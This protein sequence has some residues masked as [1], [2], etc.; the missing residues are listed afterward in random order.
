MDERS[1]ASTV[2]IHKNEYV[3]RPTARNFETSQSKGDDHK[4]EY[5]HQPMARK[6]YQSKVGFHKKEYI[7]QPMVPKTYRRKVELSTAVACARQNHYKKLILHYWLERCSIINE[8]STLTKRVQ[9][10]ERELRL[11]VTLQ[12][13]WPCKASRLAGSLIGQRQKRL[14]RK[15]HKLYEKKRELA[16]TEARL[17]HFIIKHSPDLR[18]SGIYTSRELH[19]LSPI[20]EEIHTDVGERIW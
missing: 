3:H 16:T 13:L 10:Y 14:T 20:P 19:Y 2:D 4:K 1:V 18:Y 15:Q 9:Q 5:I 7:H 17:D 8:I 12:N 11:F 6:T